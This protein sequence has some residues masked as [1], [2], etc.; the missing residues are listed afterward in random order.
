MQ[1]LV[2]SAE[3]IRVV[4]RVVADLHMQVGL[5]AHLALHTRLWRL[6]AFVPTTRNLP[7][8]ATTGLLD[9]LEQQEDDRG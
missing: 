9:V 6:L 1:P 7:V 2:G 5:L 3:H 8:A 4:Q